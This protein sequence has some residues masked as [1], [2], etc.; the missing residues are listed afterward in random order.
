M[1]RK[2]DQEK[3][4]I[5]RRRFLARSA[6]LVALGSASLLP[7]RAQ[8]AMADPGLDPMRVPGSPARTYGE[9]STFESASR[10]AGDSH[11]LTPLQELH[12]IVT[13][14]SLHFER[15][16]NGVP[17]IDPSRHRLL[18]HGLVAR[19]MLFT[20]EELQH[21]PS[22]SRLAFIECAG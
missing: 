10:S 1:S 4:S 18:L 2:G 9:R 15:H 19:P 5:D 22:V 8:A 3:G 13:P 7:G 16:H 17:A 14:S 11:S 21:F 6:S 12:G 20:V